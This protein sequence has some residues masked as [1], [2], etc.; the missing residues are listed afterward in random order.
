MIERTKLL[1]HYHNSGYGDD[2]KVNVV[3]HSMGGLVIAGYLE[4]AGNKARVAKVATLATP[5]RGSFEA[6][7]QLATGTSNLS[8][9]A[10]ALAS[11]KQ[12]AS[13]RLFTT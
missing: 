2:P 13:P 6:V 11:G 10:P 1:K 8:G 7:V 12:P 3:G 9:A 4:R 5:F